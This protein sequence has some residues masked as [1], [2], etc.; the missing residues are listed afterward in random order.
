MGKQAQ[1]AEEYSQTVISAAIEGGGTEAIVNK[2]TR[3]FAKAGV[4][5]SEHQIRRHMD[6]FLVTARHEVRSL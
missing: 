6:D 5:Q 3:D 2:L 4:E 1:E